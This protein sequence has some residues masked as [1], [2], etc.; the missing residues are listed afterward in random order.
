MDYYSQSYKKKLKTI[1]NLSQSSLWEE[2][3]NRYVEEVTIPKRARIAGVIYV[4][5]GKIVF[6]EHS[7][8]DGVTKYDMPINSWHDLHKAVTKSL[9]RK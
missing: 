9:L 6:A 2:Q 5:D 8:E 3:P 7:S 1:L 4:E